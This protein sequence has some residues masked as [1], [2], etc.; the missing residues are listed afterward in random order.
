MDE[1]GV[2]RHPLFRRWTGRSWPWGP[3]GS[4]EG[5]FGGDVL[6]GLTEGL[7]HFLAGTGIAVAS[8]ASWVALLG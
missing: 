8:Q 4:Y 6:Q 3:N 7:D 1:S 2:G 5:F